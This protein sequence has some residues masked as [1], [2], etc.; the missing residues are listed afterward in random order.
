[1]QHERRPTTSRVADFLTGGGLPAFGL[2]LIF[3]Y[4]LLLLGLV[5]TPGAE[6]GLGA[7][8]DEFRA[9]CLG[10]DPATGRIAWIAVCRYHC[11]KARLLRGATNRLSQA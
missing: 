6:T 4:E 3:C 5:L 11:V 1:V 8:A 10:Y 9:W 2:S 7:F